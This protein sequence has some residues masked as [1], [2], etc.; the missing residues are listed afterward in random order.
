M[1]LKELTLNESDQ[2]AVLI[3]NEGF[4]YALTDGGYLNPEDILAEGKDINK[5]REAIKI[6]K[7]FERICPYL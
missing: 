5:V 2:I 3:D 6:I 1:K 7:E 4:W